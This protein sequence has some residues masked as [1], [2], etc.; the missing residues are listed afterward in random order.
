[1]QPARAYNPRKAKQENSYTVDG[2]IYEEISDNQNVK[3]SSPSP[4]TMKPTFARQEQPMSD[5]YSVYIDPE[6]GLP[7]ANAPLSPR[8]QNYERPLPCKPDEDE[9]RVYLSLSNEYCDTIE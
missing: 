8:S 5:G 7:E 2:E 4:N 1:M 6:V 3:S 9:S